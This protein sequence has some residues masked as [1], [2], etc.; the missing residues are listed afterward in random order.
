MEIL[1]TCPNG[2]KN[3]IYKAIVIPRTGEIVSDGIGNLYIVE[4]VKY[5]YSNGI[6]YIEL[7][8]Y[9]PAWD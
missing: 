5:E 6:V 7:C 3:K 9:D 2:Y 8:E 1:M 4:K